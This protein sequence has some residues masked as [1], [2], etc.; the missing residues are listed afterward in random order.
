MANYY[1]PT[2]KMIR[3]LFAENGFSEP[4]PAEELRQGGYVFT[5]EHEDGRLQTA[6]AFPWSNFAVAEKDGIAPCRLII[7][8]NLDAGA[9]LGGAI[10]LANH[11]SDSF[12]PFEKGQWAEVAKAFTTTYLPLFDAPT[13]DGQTVS[14]E[15]GEV[16]LPLT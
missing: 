4:V 14:G 12:I 1:F 3:A 2:P 10:R 13:F 8:V 16:P 7:R 9:D 15:L 6:Y 5:R 11:G